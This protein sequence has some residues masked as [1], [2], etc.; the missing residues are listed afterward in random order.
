LVFA[1]GVP[2][3]SIVMLADRTH[4]NSPLAGIN[5]IGEFELTDR[6]RPGQRQIRL[7]TIH[8][9]KGLECPIVILVL[10]ERAANQTDEE[11][12]LDRFRYVAMSRACNPLFVFMPA[13]M[14]LSARG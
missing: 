5:W 8:R 1:E 11:H 13:R 3:A 10:G 6:D 14:R 12:R 4:E 7:T 9:F 2:T